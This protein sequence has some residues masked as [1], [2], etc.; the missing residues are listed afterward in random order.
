MVISDDGDV[1]YL[2][3]KDPLN[4]QKVKRIRELFVERIKKCNLK[5]AANNV[6]MKDSYMNKLIASGITNIAKKY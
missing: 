2:P 4:P 1:A 5:P 6:R 3:A